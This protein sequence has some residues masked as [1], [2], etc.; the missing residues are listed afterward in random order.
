MAKK[1]KCPGCG[2]KND[3]GKH[4]CRVCTAVIDPNADE[5][6]PKG[7]I[8]QAKMDRKLAA[9]AKRIGNDAVDPFAGLDAAA[10]RPAPSPDAPPIPGPSYGERP[11]DPQPVGELGP[12]AAGPPPIEPTFAEPVAPGSDIPAD[13]IVIEA[14]PRH[15]AVPILDEPIEDPTAW[16]AVPGIEIDVPARNATEPPSVEFDDEGFNPDDLIIDPRR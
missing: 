16:D 8:K 3:V 9:G 12:F 5:G 7:L 15:V 4:R 14:A 6:L 2:A 13:A 11:A 1:V 10:D